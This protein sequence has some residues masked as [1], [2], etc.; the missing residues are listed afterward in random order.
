MLSRTAAVALMAIV[1]GQWTVAGHAAVADHGPGEA[2]DVCLGIDRLAHGIT[3]L[4]PFPAEPPARPEAEAPPGPVASVA[5]ALHRHA[6]A[7]PVL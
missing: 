1:L 5:P 4:S 7:P 2:C 3:G 6:R